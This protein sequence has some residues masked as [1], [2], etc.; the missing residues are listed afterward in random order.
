MPL[1]IHIGDGITLDQPINS[2]RLKISTIAISSCKHRILKLGPTNLAWGSRATRTQKPLPHHISKMH[3]IFLSTFTSYSSTILRTI[4]SLNFKRIE[5]AYSQTRRNFVKMSM[6]PLA[7]WKLF[8]SGKY[9]QYFWKHLCGATGK[10][11]Q[12]FQEHIFSLKSW[13]IKLSFLAILILSKYL[14]RWLRYSPENGL[15][16]QKPRATNLTS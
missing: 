5:Y 10:S 3:V 12:T 6:F 16:L 13:V 15:R 11:Y 14:N 4:T 7:I 1:W 8:P 2:M 9:H